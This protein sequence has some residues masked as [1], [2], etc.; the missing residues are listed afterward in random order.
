LTVHIK[1]KQIDARM[2]TTLRSLFKKPPYI[3]LLGTLLSQ[4]AQT[5]RFLPA[6]AALNKSPQQLA[7]KGQ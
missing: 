4:L 3:A 7:D 5:L 1:A 6:M 2:L